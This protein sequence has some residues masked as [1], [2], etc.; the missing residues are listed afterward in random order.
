LLIEEFLNLPIAVY[1]IDVCWNPRTDR[2]INRIAGE[3]RPYDLEVF[4]WNF[5]REDPGGAGFI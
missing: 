2:H 3:L 5:D 1:T 4:D